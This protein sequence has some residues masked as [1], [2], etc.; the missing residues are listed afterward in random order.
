MS[1]HNRRDGYWKYY[2]QAHTLEKDAIV[3]NIVALVKENPP[4]YKKKSSRGRKIVHS[5]EKIVHSWEKMVCICILMIILNKTYRAMQNEVPSLKLPWNGMEPYPDHSWIAKTFKKIPL[6]Y[7]ESI[8]QKTALMCIRESN[9]KGGMIGA[10]ST[11]VE[12]DVYD[13]KERPVKH[14]NEEKKGFEKARV[15][16]FL[17][18]HVVAILD[19]LIILACNITSSRTHDS[20]VLRRMLKS[21]KRVFELHGSTM[22]A[23]GAYD[24]EANYEL[25]YNMNIHPNI[26]QREGS[27]NK[28]LRYRKKAS[29]EFDVDVYHYRGLIEGIFGAEE[30]AGHQLH[31]RYIIRKNQKKFG[32]IKAIGWNVRVLNRLKCANRMGIQVSPYAIAN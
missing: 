15:K 26:R 30:K 1:E 10:D 14:R 7:L 23:D 5:W 29:K 6:Q 17:K 9:W 22:N 8:L 28:I 13:K 32:V 27:V 3:R 25:L 12:T 4:P 19:Y 18:W 20:P 2:H 24:G 31:C 21:M 16:R 11:G